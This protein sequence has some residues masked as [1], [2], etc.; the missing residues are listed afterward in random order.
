MHDTT[1]ALVI[2]SLFTTT[3]K[4]AEIEGDLLEQARRRGR[5]WFW[6]QIKL[7]CIALF[8]H[9]LWREAG[10]LLLIGYAVYEL[11]LKLNWWALN[12]L[13]F[14]L[15]RGLDL[16]ASQLPVMDNLVVTLTAF[17]LAMLS[18]RL[19]PGHSFRIIVLAAG[20]MCGR[21]LLLDDIADVPRFLAFAL[22]PGIAGAIVMKWMMLNG[23]AGQS[24][25]SR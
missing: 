16:D 7:T 24:H 23:R 5:V 11:V 6:W 20:F 15:W 3:D 10:K 22:L 13:R 8:F 2:L 4:A 17:S 14:A 25:A 18:T 1:L 21:F 9:G 12:P 19:S